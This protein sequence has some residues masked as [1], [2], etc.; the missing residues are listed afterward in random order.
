MIVFL[1]AVRPMVH[2]TEPA[3]LAHATSLGDVLQDRF[4]LLVGESGTEKDCT[5]AFGKAR[6]AGAAPEHASGLVGAVAAGQGEVSQP[7]FAVVGALGIEAREAREVV[8]DS[9][10]SMH[11]RD[12]NRVVVS[13]TCTTTAIQDAI[14]LGHEVPPPRGLL[15]MDGG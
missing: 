1:S 7:S 10:P 8:H 13:P 6:L 4:N 3:G 5:L 11:P 9:A 2:F 15:L 14:D 12:G